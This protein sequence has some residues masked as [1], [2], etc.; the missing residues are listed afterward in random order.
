MRSNTRVWLIAGSI[1]I[2]ACGSASTEGPATTTT[3]TTDVASTATPSTTTVPPSSTTLPP[4]G[5]VFESISLY[6]LNTSTFQVNNQTFPQFA[7]SFELDSTLDVTSVRLA[8]SMAMV[9]QPEYFTAPFVDQWKYYTTEPNFGPFTFDVTTTIY[10]TSTG[11]LVSDLLD[12]TEGFDEVFRSTSTVR[13]D[14]TI[15]YGDG[16]TG[17]TNVSIELGEAVRLDPGGHVVVMD[18]SWPDRTVFLL[19]MFGRQSGDNTRSGYDQDQPGDC[20]YAASD[21]ANPTGRA[22]TGVGIGTWD[23]TADGT[24]GI[25]TRF[26]PAMAKVSE[27]FSAGSYNDIWN[28]GDVYLVLFGRR[29][30]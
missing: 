1:G 27:C 7:Q 19:R 28:Q 12:V 4:E 21:D 26:R 13:M 5:I 16:W 9:V 10:R 23:G 8:M 3:P 11:E 20:E 2:A 17:E 14:K 6:D 25:G 18:F 24:V 22:Y 15:G 30:A 29:V